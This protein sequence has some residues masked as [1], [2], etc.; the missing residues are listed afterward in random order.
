MQFLA[1]SGNN[2]QVITTGTGA[3]AG[4]ITINGGGVQIQATGDRDRSDA[5]NITITTSTGNLTTVG[6]I[7][8][9]GGT[10]AI[11][12]SGSASVSGGLTSAGSNIDITADNGFTISGSASVTTNGGDFAVDADADGNGSGTYQQLGSVDASGTVLTTVC[13]PVDDDHIGFTSV[14]GTTPLAPETGY[15]GVRRT[16]LLIDDS[17][18]SGSPLTHTNVGSNLHGN[19]VQQTGGLLIDLGAV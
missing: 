10:I 11:D 13:I 9:V 2:A 17:G 1:F 4:D 18:L 15:T 14:G 6:D 12:V 7:T 5:G 3:D 16:T 19:A 8:A